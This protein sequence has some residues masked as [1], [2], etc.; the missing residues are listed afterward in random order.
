MS[1][2]QKPEEAGER[3]PFPRSWAPRRFSNCLL[4]RGAS[5]SLGQLIVNDATRWFGL[6]ANC[7]KIDAD[8]LAAAVAVVL[9]VKR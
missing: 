8:A 5:A 3:D 7:Q 1:D 2:E 9:D 6:C 4:C